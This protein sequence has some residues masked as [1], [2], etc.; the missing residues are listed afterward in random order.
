MDRDQHDAWSRLRPT[1]IELSTSSSDG[2]GFWK[3]IT[4][5]WKG[6]KT[7]T[8]LHPSMQLL[9]LSTKIK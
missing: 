1:R 8:S 6:S 7:E 3:N 4:F 5:W 2:Q 9:I